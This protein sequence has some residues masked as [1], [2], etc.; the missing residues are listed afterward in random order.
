MKT[1]EMAE[2][3]NDCWNRRGSMR[4]SARQAQIVRFLSRNDGGGGSFH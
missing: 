3:Q 2:R 4:L 1:V